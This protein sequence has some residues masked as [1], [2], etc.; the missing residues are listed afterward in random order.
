M[1]NSTQPVKNRPKKPYNISNWP[2]LLITLP[3]NFIKGAAPFLLI[4]LLLYGIASRPTYN[5]SPRM[6]DHHS[7]YE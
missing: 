7:C 1:N 2:L 3:F 6:C 4:M 5:E